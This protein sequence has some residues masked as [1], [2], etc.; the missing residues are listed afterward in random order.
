MELIVH[1]DRVQ[2]SAKSTCY[3]GVISDWSMAIVNSMLEMSGMI[4]CLPYC[5][6]GIVLY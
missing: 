5:T 4:A 6:L 1:H 2:S 3:V